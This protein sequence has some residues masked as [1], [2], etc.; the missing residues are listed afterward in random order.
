MTD[1]WGYPR[2]ASGD[3]GKQVVYQPR[4][5]QHVTT[6]A[7]MLTPIPCKILFDNT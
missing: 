3:S 5:N 1:S 2:I 7:L 6:P 4:A